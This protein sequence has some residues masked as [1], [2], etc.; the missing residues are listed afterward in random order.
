MVNWKRTCR[1]SNKEGLQ[2][3]TKERKKITPLM[4]SMLAPARGQRSLVNGLHLPIS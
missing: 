4:L 1:V 3:C 2:V